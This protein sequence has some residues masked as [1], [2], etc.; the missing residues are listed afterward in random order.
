MNEAGL[1]VERIPEKT[2]LITV[3]LLQGLISLA[4]WMQRIDS[5]HRQKKPVA[6]KEN[7]VLG[8]CPKLYPNNITIPNN[9]NLK[10][11]A[12]FGNRFVQKIVAI[13]SSHIIGLLT[14]FAK[15]PS[16]ADNVMSPLLG[17]ITGPKGPLEIVSAIV[18]PAESK[19]KI[20]SICSSL[21]M[22]F[23]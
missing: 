5:L 12:S 4:E 9:V 15:K 23:V 10:F 21:F 17:S 2:C 7:I 16:L 8:M 18:M 22:V 19:M 13:T 3:K 11:R 20:K 1:S 6:G 14:A